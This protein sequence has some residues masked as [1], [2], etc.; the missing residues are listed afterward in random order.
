M[1]HGTDGGGL[2]YYLGAAQNLIAVW[3][4]AS[5][6]ALVAARKRFDSWEEMQVIDCNRFAAN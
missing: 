4:F 3:K 1:I 5:R 6:G 2:A